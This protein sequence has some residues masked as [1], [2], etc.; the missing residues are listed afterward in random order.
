M[1]VELNVVSYVNKVKGKR[2]DPP[3][4]RCKKEEARKN[5]G[6]KNYVE[7]S[8]HSMVVIKKCSLRLS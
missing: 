8:E 1:L 7:S 5:G 3:T 6:N 4:R 2:N